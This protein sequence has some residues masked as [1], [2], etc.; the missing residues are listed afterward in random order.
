[1]RRYRRYC[2]IIMLFVGGGWFSLPVFFAY[3]KMW[4]NHLQTADTHTLSTTASSSLVYP[5]NAKQGLKF[6]LPQDSSQLRIITN[7]HIKGTDVMTI[8]PNW[9]YALHYELL[10]KKGAILTTGVY[11]QHSRLT[12]YKDAEGGLIQGN[13]YANKDLIPLDGRLILLGL[14]AVKEAAFLRLSFESTNPAVIETAVRVYAP[15]KI[16]EH[17]IATS[18]LRM[19]EEQKDSLA[20]YSIYPAFLLSAAEKINLLKHQWQPIGPTGIEGKNYLTLNL[21]TLKDKEIDNQDTLMLA[22]GLQA[23]ATHYGVIPLPE[24]GGQVSLSFKAL[25][26]S[27]LTTPVA[28]NLQ[29]FGRDKEQRWQQNANWSKDTGDLTYSLEGGLLVIRPSSPVII[30]ASLTTATAPKQDI[31]ESLLSL[32]TYITSFGVDFDVLHYQQHPAA[33]RVDVRRLL[34]PTVKS[35]QEQVRYQWLNA[36]GTV[37]ASGELSALEQASLFDR[38]GDITEPNNVSDSVSYYFRLPKEVTRVRLL[39]SSPTLLVNA[40]NQPYGVTKWQRVPE[41]SYIDSDKQ[42]LELTWFP[43]RAVNDKTLTQQQA[44]QWL[45]G[46]YRPTEDKPD[47]M[48]GQY[49]WQDF[50][51]QSELTGRYLLTD[52]TNDEPR[53]DALASVYCAL[54]VNR[55]NPIKLAASN[56]LRSISPELIFLRDNSRPFTAELFAN[57][58]KVL[59]MNTMGQQGIL[60]L[61]EMAVG[62]QRLRLNTDSGGRWLMNYQEHCTGEQ[63]LKRR[64]FALNTNA[65]LDFIVQHAAADE[66]LSARWYSPINTVDRSQIKVDIEAINAT[67][68]TASIFTNWTY[69]NRLYDIRLLPSKAM[70]VLYT[71]GQIVTNGERFAIPLNSDL[72]AGAYRIRLALAKGA[73]GLVTLSQIKAGNYEQRRFFRETELKTH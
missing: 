16:A 54:V 4:F 71:Q 43:L 33:L 27:A 52:Y 67:S 31:S 50:M 17:Q 63:L 60:H 40:Y 19:T 22:S 62:N 49:L 36:S 29:W 12:M 69:L 5:I 48:Q 20:K 41:D 35:Q 51:P 64:V 6:A 3:T 42:N 56:G 37:I 46:Q 7:A 32:K 55:D 30:S 26:G 15:T 21:Y 13:Y 65:P 58:E 18:W 73:A 59:M 53:A 68:S 47:V 1:M 39:S 23:D 61:P 11:H 2:L 66:T 34:I 72:P 44:V 10:D 25:D 24:Q 9:T 8:D 38:A 57:Q 45:S 14:H 70:P 28:V